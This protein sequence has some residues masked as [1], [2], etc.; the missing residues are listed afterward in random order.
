[1]FPYTLKPS[2]MPGKHRNGRK[3]R[4]CFYSPDTV[5]M[6]PIHGRRRNIK[7]YLPANHRRCIADTFRLYGNMLT[8]I[9][10]PAVSILEEHSLYLINSWERCFSV[11]DLF[12]KWFG[13]YQQN[14]QKIVL[15]N[16]F[17]V[18]ENS[19]NFIDSPQREPHLCLC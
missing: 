19:L 6:S 13:F 11:A 7:K 3:S 5:T 16:C 2:S 1:M 12:W 9:W 18:S 14:T 15:R 17:F 8:I 4:T 10:K